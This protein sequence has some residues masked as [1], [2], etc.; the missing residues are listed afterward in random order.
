LKQNGIRDCNPE[1]APVYEDKMKAKESKKMND[2]E[3]KEDF[4]PSDVKKKEKL[5]KK[6]K[7]NNEIDKNER[8][9]PFKGSSETLIAGEDFSV[10][11]ES[12]TNKIMEKLFEKK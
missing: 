9:Q 8:L 4:V 1:P 5:N 10:V 11:L 6:D 3:K 2:L 12:V 7:S